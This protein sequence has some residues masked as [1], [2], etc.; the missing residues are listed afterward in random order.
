SYAYP[1]ATTDPVSATWSR[2]VNLRS[3]SR[4]SRRN[5]AHMRIATPSA[6]A[7]ANA[8][9]RRSRRRLSGMRRAP[10][11]QDVSDAPDGVHQGERLVPVHFAPDARNQ[12]VHGVAERVEVVVPDVLQDLT[13]ADHAARV[14]KEVFQQGELAGRQPEL[15][16]ATAHHAGGDLELEVRHPECH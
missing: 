8:A 15:A 5:S 1:I 10:V 11:G 6:K 16:P 4:R 2:R 3:A 14:P 12:D 13:S 9:E 7:S